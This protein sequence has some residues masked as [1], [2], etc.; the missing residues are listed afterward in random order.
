MVF[1]EKL[2]AAT[3]L[4]RYKRF[5]AD[6]VLDDGSVLTAYCPNTGSMR[7][8][9]TPGSRVY[10]SYSA[11]KTRKYPHTLEMIRE[12]DTWIGVNTGLTNSIV[13]EA[14]RQGKIGE[15]GQVENIATEVKVSAK[16]RLDVAV[17]AAGKTIY[18]EV[19]NC[20]LVENGIAMFP[21]A[22]TARGT[23]HLLELKELVSNGCG[24]II[25]YLVQ[26]MDAKSFAPASH[27]D[28]LYA[29]T[30]AEVCEQGVQVVVYQAEVTP[31][32]IEVVGPLPYS[33]TS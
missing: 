20:S 24:G 2:I 8:C 19:K 1:K 5:L 27:L 16:S 33:V 14:I 22:V 12:A 11:S 29:R 32:E 23:K 30:L 21:D 26:R 7:S 18:I 10:L 6:V 31:E 15:L 17:V 13:T 9:S 28:P 3:L 4:K 25:F